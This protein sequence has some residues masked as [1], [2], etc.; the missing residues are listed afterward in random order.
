MSK[1]TILGA[2]EAIETE[3]AKYLTDARPCKR[4]GNTWKYGIDI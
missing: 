2:G 1:Q 4:H 3:L